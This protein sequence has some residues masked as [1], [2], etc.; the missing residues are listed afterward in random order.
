MTKTENVR[1]G[2]GAIGCAL[3]FKKDTIQRY[4]GSLEYWKMLWSLVR[5]KSISHVMLLQKSDW[6]DLPEN[7]KIEFDPRGVLFDPYSEEP[8][9]SRASVTP[10]KN[11]DTQLCTNYRNFYEHFKDKHNLDTAY[12]FSGMGYFTNNSIPNF[13]GAVRI[14]EHRVRVQWVTYNYCAPVVHF[15]NMTKL[16]WYNVS[17]DPRYVKDVYRQR[18]TMNTPREIISQFEKA[19]TWESVDCYEGNEETVGNETV[20]HLRLEATGIEKLARIQEPIYPPDNDRPIRLLMGV[21]QS[22]YGQGAGY[23][24]RLEM[25]K[26]WV[27]KYDDKKEVEIYGKWSPEVIAGYEDWFKGMIPYQEMDAKLRQ[28]RYT[29][30]KG[31]RADWSTAKWADTLAQ[32]VVPF[33]VPGYDT[34]NSVVPA[35]HFIRVKT[36]E[37]LYK[38]MDYLDA[39]PDKRIALVKGLQYNLLKEAKTGT[40]VYDIL[41]KSFKRT[42][43]DI[44]LS[45][46]RDDSVKR[47]SKSKSLF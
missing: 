17:L 5:N 35:D 22:K 7:E 9:F 8:G 23:D 11:E 16:P 27:F 31:I 24:D 18:D 45:L 34:Q 14:P 20:K 4:D 10:K 25:L 1:I 47:K 13:L 12:L 2:F 29:V 15:L 36:P 38:K 26:T 37:D 39:N 19:V 46:E 21:M 40:F 42:G 41:N 43:I 33:L 28:T 30:V 6:A 3:K 32:G 44:E